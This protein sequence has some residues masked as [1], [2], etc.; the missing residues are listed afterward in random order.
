MRVPRGE[1]APP[2]QEGK[3]LKRFFES[4]RPYAGDMA[5]G[6]ALIPFVTGLRLVQPYLLKV[7]IDGDQ[8]TMLNMALLLAGT[9]LVGYAFESV[10]MYALQRAGHRT[11]SDMRR[12]LFGHVL[13]Q[14]TSF[15][16]RRP[17]GSLLSRVSS[18]TESVGQSFTL[19]LITMFGD[20]LLVA[21]TVAT[22][23]WLDA[24]VTVYV[25]L[26]APPIIIVTRLFQRLLRG[27]ADEIRR[28]VAR[29]NSVIEENLAGI[30]IVHLFSRARQSRREGEEQSH[31]YFALYSRFNVADAGLYAIMESL[32]ALTVGA[33][34][35][36]T[37]G[38]VLE[39]MM[40]LGLVVA[41][42]EYAQRAFV[43]IREL[44]G[45]LAA[46][47]SAF[48]S[49]DRMDNTLSFSEHSPPGTKRWEK[50][51]GAIDFEQLT[52]RYREQGP[53]VLE[54]LDLHIRPGERVAVVGPT[55]S[56]KTTLL[57]LLTRHYKPSAGSIL[58]DGHPV[59]EVRDVDFRAGV[60]IIRQDVFLFEGTIYENVALG[61]PAITRARVRD[62]LDATGI[63]RLVEGR[64][65]GL[66]AH[67]EE[68]GRNLSAGEGQLLTLARIFARDPTVVLLD[69]ATARVDSLTE[70]L[71]S[72]A[73][74]RLM[75]GRT[76]IAVAHRLS[77]VREADR[78]LVMVRG[79]IAESG[80]HSE[81]LAANGLY[82]R[83]WRHRVR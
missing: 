25:L 18:D 54:G 83:M 3:G 13:S 44:S 8:G 45:K 47:Q 48:A 14:G 46:L 62:S 19:G 64:P 35:W 68:R 37:A 78:I 43:P 58:L 72:E 42:V 41:F 20:V 60:G 4:A 50:R 23:L 73:I 63:L 26:L 16:D 55:G 69:E 75:K 67:V 80:T 81:L 40:T 6:A 33:V 9:V 7:A 24:S 39:G 2:G 11:I 27:Y 21:G 77:T 49:L 56:G 71:I 34:L 70:A 17:V 5:L 66:D 65:G 52:F 53:D 30:D 74:A 22:M 15:F 79:R 1:P 82:A 51:E 12:R 76:V 31:R 57:N 61:D 59:D 38:P 29:M 28:L 10:H 32:S 36:F